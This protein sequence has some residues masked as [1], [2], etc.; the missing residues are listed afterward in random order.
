VTDENVDTLR[1]VYA[2]FN[3]GD[4]DEAAGAFH[5][6]IEVVPAGGLPPYRGVESVR[7]WMEP[8]ALVDQSFE[9]LEFVTSGDRILVKQRVKGRGA[10]SGME[11]DA[12]S[13][14][15]CTFGEDGRLLRAEAFMEYE[16]AKAREAAGL[17]AG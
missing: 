14:A 15:V 9:P 3:R 12:I 13:F 5:P 2:A 4:F 17:D 8:D 11:V 6:E 16:E 7:A 1:R 10:S